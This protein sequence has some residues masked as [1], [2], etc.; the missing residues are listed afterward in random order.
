MTGYPA[1]PDGCSLRPPERADA[2]AIARLIG[3]W[4][5][6]R[7]LSRVPHPYALSAAEWWLDQTLPAIEAGRMRTC[8]IVV[9]GCFAGVCSKEP[10]ATGMNLGFWLGRPYWGRRI[11]TAA[12][13]TL[14]HEHFSEPDAAHLVSGYFKGN[15]ASA[16]IQRRLGFV[17]IGEG[18]RLSRPHGG[19]RAHVETALTRA[20]YQLA[21]GACEPLSPQSPRE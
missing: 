6:A 13:G 8:A 9:G 11:M 20:A 2:A 1:L 7:W 12:A 16:A 17:E 5:V 10:M 15:A 14:V 21:R 4:E 19:L 3:D 18:Q